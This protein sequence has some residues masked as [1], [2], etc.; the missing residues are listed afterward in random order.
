M[1]GTDGCPAIRFAA[2]I[3]N[4][5]IVVADTSPLCYLVRIDCVEILPK[6]FGRVLIPP[7]V[8]S[9]LLHIRCVPAINQPL[10]A[11]GFGCPVYGHSSTG[12]MAFFAS[13][14]QASI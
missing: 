3:L 8:E 5:M 14:F 4:L 1:Y 11:A 13:T 9:V 6:L 2:R 10:S 12:H 7:Q